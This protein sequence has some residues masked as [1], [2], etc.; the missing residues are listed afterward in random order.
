MPVCPNC[1]Y[2]YVEGMTICPDCGIRLVDDDYFVQPEEWTEENWQVVYTSGQEYDVEMLR[3]NLESAG[4]KTSIL[5]QKDRNFPAPG[6][7]SL[8]KLYVRK[9]DVQSALNFIEELKT[10]QGSDEDEEE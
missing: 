9:E 5:S 8:V 1:E 4:I 7:F 6:D 2:E 3:D 10:E